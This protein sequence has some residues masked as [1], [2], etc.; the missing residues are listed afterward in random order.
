MFV[1]GY[2]TN[3]AVHAVRESTIEGDRGTAACRRGLVVDVAGPSGLTPALSPVD[4][5]CGRC[6]RSLR[7]KQAPAEPPRRPDSPAPAGPPLA[8]AYVRV[9]TAEQAEEGISLDAQRAKLIEV[10]ESRGYR[11]EVVADEGKSGKNMN[12]PGLQSA[13]KRLDA[14]EASTLLAIRIDRV[15]RSVLDF[16]NLLA[17]SN[18]RGWNLVMLNPEIDTTTP[19]GRLLVHIM[20]SLAQFEREM[21][22]ERTREALAHRRAQ[23]AK[24]GGRPVL[25]PEVVRRIV[26]ERA[27]GLTLRAIAAGLN[28]DHV[29]TGRDG[30]EWYAST[31]SAVLSSATAREFV[32]A[33][34]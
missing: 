32:A 1:I 34:A 6:A 23:G 17:R 22:G 33:D 31:I 19:A 8:L 28:D 3:G 14:G 30:R 15:S 9:S 7:A 12:R 21:I 10:G 29:P 18:D 20:V 13:L 5:T 25:P 24:I 16:S 27:S 2:A 4:V 11:V 26:E